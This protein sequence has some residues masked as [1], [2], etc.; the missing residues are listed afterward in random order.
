[1]LREDMRPSL[2]LGLLLAGVLVLSA[3]ISVA[4]AVTKVNSTEILDNGNLAVSIE[5]RGMK[6]FASVG[7]QLHATATA[8]SCDLTGQQCI[9]QLYENLEEAVTLTPDDKGAVAGTLTETDV[10]FPSG[11]PCTCGPRHV[12]YYDMTLTNLMTGHVYSLDPISRDYP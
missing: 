9:A 3:G 2:G 8:K 7:Y 12:E 5:E 11:V 6:K 1:M 4:G 10:S